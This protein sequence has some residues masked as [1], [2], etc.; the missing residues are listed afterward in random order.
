MTFLTYVR[1]D[2]YNLTGSLSMKNLIRYETVLMVKK[3]Y[4][5]LQYKSA[6]A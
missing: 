6:S 1:N 5:F 3:I 2:S 4:W